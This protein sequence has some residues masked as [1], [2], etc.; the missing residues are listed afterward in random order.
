MGDFDATYLTIPI[1][2]WYKGGDWFM[3]GIGNRM[4]FLISQKM[5]GS[6]I[7]DM[8]RVFRDAIVGQ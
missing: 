3:F 6:K 2:Y 7:E 4:D 8:F 1:Q 5:D